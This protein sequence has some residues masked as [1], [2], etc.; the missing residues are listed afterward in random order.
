[1][2]KVGN[3]YRVIIQSSCSILSRG[4]T[5][6]FLCSSFL[7]MTCSL[8]KGYYILPKE[9]LHRSLQGQKRPWVF[10][11]LGKTCATQAV[12][13]HFAPE[14]T[15]GSGAHSALVWNR[16]VFAPKGPTTRFSKAHWVE[17]AARPTKAGRQ[18]MQALRACCAHF[19]AV[20]TGAI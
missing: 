5:W 18:L 1:M 16:D 17:T 15:S 4:S 11:L 2:T 13:G 14:R 10:G 7:V 20:A 6:R 19:G 8:N 9:E 3:W 12:F